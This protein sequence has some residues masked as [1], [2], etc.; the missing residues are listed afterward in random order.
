VRRT[1]H[2]RGIT[3][4][5][6]RLGPRNM[7]NSLNS[8]VRDQG[9][10]APTIGA[11]RPS[12][13]LL[14]VALAATLLVGCS[15]DEEQRSLDPVQL[16]M[17][18]D[19][20]PVFDDGEEQT[21]EVKLPVGF[22]MVQP[23]EAQL[24]SLSAVE[25]IPNY[26][27]HYPWINSGDVDIQITWTLSN[28]DAETH[29]VWLLIDPWNE[30]GRYWPGFQEGEEG[31]MIPNFSG[32]QFYFEVPG[33]ESGRE[34]RRHGTLTFEDMR[35]LAI[36]FA[37]VMNLLANPPASDDPDYDPTATYANHA[38]HPDN[39]SYKDQL[40]SNSGYL[41]TLV[42]GLT[43]IDLGLRTHERAN[44]A[45]EI[46]IEIVDKGNQKVLDKDLTPWPEPAEFIT[47]GTGGM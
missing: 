31:E 23:T 3:L 20:D 8:T 10:F 7:V 47:V 40:I 13:T 25:N 28:L 39:R 33:T 37:T 34:T 44:V 27:S 5:E 26:L 14:G 35:E 4:D 17:T 1:W 21:F 11:A 45:V 12:T 38:F 42:P 2:A 18:S 15:D 24:N 22:P 9:V 16:G 32:I 43:G 6:L 29:N 19:M 41:P 46:G 36:D 30:F